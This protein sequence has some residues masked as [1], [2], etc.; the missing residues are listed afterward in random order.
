MIDLQ[1]S[2]IGAFPCCLVLYSLEFLK[3]EIK[4]ISPVQIVLRSLTVHYKK[5]FYV[6]HSI[7]QGQG[8]ILSAL[9]CLDHFCCRGD[10]RNQTDVTGRERKNTLDI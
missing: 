6:L 5:S 7:I 1:I 4:I 8:Y 9:H 10:N 3:I 2:Q